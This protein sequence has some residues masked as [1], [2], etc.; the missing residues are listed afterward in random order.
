MT[1]ADWQ[2]VVEKLLL[3]SSG[4]TEK[5]REIADATSAHLEP[6]TPERVAAA[7]LRAHLARPLGLFEPR[8]ISDAEYEYL[9]RVATE[10]GMLIPKK[11]EDRDLLDAWLH[12][13]WANRAAFH[14]KRLRPEV[15]D[16]AVI[17]EEEKAKGKDG[18]YGEISSISDDG[19][20]NFRGVRGGRVRPH[21]V[22]RIVKVGE[23][24]HAD[25]VGKVREEALSRNRYP[26]RVT[27]SELA[28]LEPW[29][30]TRDPSL[31][32][33]G[34]FRDA[35]AGATKERPMQV[36]LEKH[37]SLFSKIIL[38]GNH[39]IW[40]RP[41][42]QF[43]NHYMAD[44]LVAIRNSAGLYWVLV[45]LE[46]PTHRLTNPGNG[47]ASSALRHAVDQIEDWRK[48]LTTNLRSARAPREDG[49]L[50]LPGINVNARGLIVMGRE[51]VSDSA[52][53]IRERYSSQSGIEIRTYDSLVR[54]AEGEGAMVQ[55][56]PVDKDESLHGGF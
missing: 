53:D 46:S 25:L 31:A 29:K 7:L 33:L 20:L 21:H 14:L 37:P 36:A 8:S 9:D 27:N 26:E 35:L 22:K 5:Q 15:G 51:D 41:Q 45:E 13:A 55:G 11:I 47:R 50:G 38:G 23:E 3:M 24:D 34:A 17:S 18:R 56:M 10:A 16:V 39:G 40:V 32:D 49:G 43:G 2:K 54:T 30:V 52:T 4:P 28:L 42:V 12:V 6:K 1:E 44:F 48:W 19:R